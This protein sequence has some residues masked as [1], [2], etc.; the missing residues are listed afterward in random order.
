MALKVYNTLIDSTWDSFDGIGDM[1]HQIKQIA[2]N[3]A[4][5]ESRIKKKLL[6]FD[7]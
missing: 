4:W 6:H 5:C 7:S 3:F 2:L 1:T